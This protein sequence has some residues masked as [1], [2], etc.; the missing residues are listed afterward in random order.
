MKAEEYIAQYLTHKLK[1]SE[2]DSGKIAKRMAREQ[3]A[4]SIAEGPEI[5]LTGGSEDVG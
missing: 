4:R 2:L 1:E 3:V 5:A